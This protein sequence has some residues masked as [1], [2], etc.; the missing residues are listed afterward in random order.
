MST[1][2]APAL[3]AFVDLDDSLFSSTR[4]CAPHGV[5]GSGGAA[6]QPAA[7]LQNG[8]V[9]SYTNPRQRLLLDWLRRGAMLVPVT[10]RSV[11]GLSRVLLPFDGPA[12]TSFGGVILDAQRQPDALWAS[13]MRAVLAQA[14]PRLQQACAAMAAAIAQRGIDAWARLVEEHGQAQ[15]LLLKHRAADVAA[16]AALRSELLQPWAAAHPG[17]RV[18]QNDNNL[19]L[20]PPGLDKAHAVA[21]LMAGLRAQHA[22]LLSLGIGDS[23]SDAGFLGLCDYAMTPRHSQLSQRLVTEEPL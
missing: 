11:E 7:L 2:S 6:L 21:H 18:F 9:I 22:E 17:W 5:D 13:R 8:A 3:V 23:L 15:Y 16:L 1:P 12:V 19:V 4:K 20:L 14:A 10:A